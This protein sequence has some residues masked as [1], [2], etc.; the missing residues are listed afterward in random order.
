MLKE[1]DIDEKRQQFIASLP[2]TLIPNKYLQTE[3]VFLNAT[4]DKEFGN[5]IKYSIPKRMMD[6]NDV[7]L[8]HSLFQVKYMG[9]VYPS[10]RVVLKKIRKLTNSQLEPVINFHC[11][12]NRISKKEQNKLEKWENQLSQ[13]LVRELMP[14]V[15]AFETDN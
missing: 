6:R 11:P 12:S 10:G 4:K 7:Y 1:C 5:E 8:N 14:S 15:I 3:S 9:I 2:I 13:S